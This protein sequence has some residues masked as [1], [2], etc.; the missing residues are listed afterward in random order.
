MSILKRLKS[1]VVPDTAEGVRYECADCGER[2]E[3]SIDVCP[4]CGSEEF[5]ER[6]SFE[7]RPG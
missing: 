5:V 4:S 2:V 3:E 6:E 1:M 7:M